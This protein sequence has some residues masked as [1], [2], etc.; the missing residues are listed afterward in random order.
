M[1]HINSLNSII[2]KIKVYQKMHLKL[3]LWKLTKKLYKIKAN[4]NNIDYY[5]KLRIQMRI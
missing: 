1:K 4:K 5:N 3:E 2:I